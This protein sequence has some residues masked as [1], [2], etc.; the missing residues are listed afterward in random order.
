MQFVTLK[1]YKEG[2]KIT[3]DTAASFADILVELEELFAKLQADIKH[4]IDKKVVFDIDTGDRILSLDEKQAIEKQVSN[5]PRLSIHRITADVIKIEDALNIM[6]SRNIHINGKVIR[7]GQ[8]EKVN[9]DVLFLGNLH[10]GATL[11]ATGS[12]FVLGEVSGIIHAG[13]NDDSQA[14]IVGDVSQAQQL[15]VGDVVNIVE[16]EDQERLLKALVYVNDLHSL[17]YTTLDKL[18]NLRPKLFL[19]T[20]GF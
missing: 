15:R 6:E 11:Q 3:L 12:I 17:E 18:K 19:K 5:Y 14:I 4:D 7:N 16:E 8:V 13:F 2:Y 9:G 1:G 10:Q 20:G